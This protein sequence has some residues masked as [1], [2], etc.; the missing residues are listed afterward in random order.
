MI[1]KKIP[2]KRFILENKFKE[3]VYINNLINFTSL[4]ALFLILCIIGLRF[5]LTFKFLIDTTIN[6]IIEFIV[7]KYKENEEFKLDSITKIP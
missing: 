4:S 7:R 5:V 2:D 1:G 6:N 3:F